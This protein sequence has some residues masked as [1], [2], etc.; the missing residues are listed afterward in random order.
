MLAKTRFAKPPTS[1]VLEVNNE[2]H[3]RPYQSPL[4]L[5]AFIGS[6]RIYCSTSF[7]EAGA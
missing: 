5:N 1:A 7:N 6:V 3:G 4:P 2:N